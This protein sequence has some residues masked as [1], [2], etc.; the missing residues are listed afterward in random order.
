MKRA[1]KLFWKGDV[2]KALALLEKFSND[3]EN[4]RLA[5]AAGDAAAAAESYGKKQLERAIANLEQGRYVSARHT[6][7]RLKKAFKGSPIGVQAKAK[8]AEIQKDK[9]I[10]MELQGA[11]L[12]RMSMD[13]YYAKDYKKAAAPLLKITRSKMF[14]G[15]KV[16]EQAERQLKKLEFKL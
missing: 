6:L 5:Q 2:G 11:T 1:R 13:H 3:P 4:P 12:L 9:S 14:A 10:S 7:R 15:T 16:R 8:L